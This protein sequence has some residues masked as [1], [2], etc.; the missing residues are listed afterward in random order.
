MNSFNL[1]LDK[2]LS[3]P[4]LAKSSVDKNREGEEILICDCPC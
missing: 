1:S 3:G 2:V 4:S